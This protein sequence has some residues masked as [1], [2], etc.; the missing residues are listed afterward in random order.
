MP[1]ADT[2]A[3][4]TGGSASPH[5]LLDRL[6]HVRAGLR[7]IAQGDVIGRVTATDSLTV[8]VAGLAGLLA[9]GDRLEIALPDGAPLVAEV[10]KLSSEAGARAMA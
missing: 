5:A 9:R 1:P 10:V 7:R 2:P 6:R 3:G 4:Q 8:E